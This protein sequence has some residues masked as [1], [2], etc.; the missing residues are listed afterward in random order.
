MEP[1]AKPLA[2]LLSKLPTKQGKDA[3]A[4][5]ERLVGLLAAE[6]GG[7]GADTA[8][9][10]ATALE[11]LRDL[12]RD[13][14]SAAV[15]RALTLIGAYHYLSASP[16]SGIE[17]TELAVRRAR[18]LGETAPLC[19]AL[20]LLVVLRG[21]TG[22]YPEATKAGAEG[23]SAAQAA[24][25]FALES[26]L[27][28]NLGSV[29]QYAGQYSEST[30]CFEKVLALSEDRPDMAAIRKL[31][32]TNIA[33]VS[34]HMN[35]L[36]RGLK[37]ARQALELSA[38]PIDA[39]ARTQRVVLETCYARLLLEAGALLDARQHADLAR[40]LDDAD[41][42]RVHHAEQSDQDRHEHQGVEE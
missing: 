37:A 30:A 34:L 4:E 17:A 24:G 7:K 20:K 42:H 15:V 11:V 23:I 39:E 28:L 9:L 35:D 19:K 5:I 8:I 26:E 32:F 6:L 10:F 21:E 31:A 22:N 33:V 13:V 29:H 2:D 18:D 38:E 1:V 27:W 3:H 25:D 16:S 36:S 40:A 41:E 14:N 12:P